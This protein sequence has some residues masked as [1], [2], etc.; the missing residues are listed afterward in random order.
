MFGAV[1]RVGCREGGLQGAT[2]KSSSGFRENE[3][4]RD[5]HM[6]LD[7]AYHGLSQFRTLFPT[8]NPRQKRLGRPGSRP[9]PRDRDRFRHSPP[10]PGSVPPYPNRP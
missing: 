9:S 7:R 10:L 8:G 3:E 2:G 5:R 4:F 1:E 6:L